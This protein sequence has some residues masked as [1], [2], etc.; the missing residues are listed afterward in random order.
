MGV[1]SGAVTE[2]Y[3]CSIVVE[4][5]LVW[6]QLGH[7]DAILRRLVRGTEAEPLF[8]APRA[9]SD[10]DLIQKSHKLLVSLSV[11]KGELCLLLEAALPSCGLKCKLFGLSP[12]AHWRQLEEVTSDYYL[13]PSE[14]SFHFSYAPT[15]EVQI[16][17]R[18][19]RERKGLLT[20]LRN[21]L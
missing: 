18:K 14:R 16:V 8:C 11:H 15:D 20:R 10:P 1:Y 6:V 5:Y 9:V 2:G 7:G 3:E 13:N 21:V 17:L 19:W 12:L 4:T